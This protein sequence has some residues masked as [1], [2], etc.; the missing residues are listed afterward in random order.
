M[1]VPFATSLHAAAPFVL[2]KAVPF[3]T[4]LLA[5]VHFVT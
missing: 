5:A 3:A 1:A 4:L 2:I